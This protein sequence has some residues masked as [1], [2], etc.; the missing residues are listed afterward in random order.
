[1]P[2]KKYSRKRNNS[3]QMRR[4]SRNA[5]AYNHRSINMFGGALEGDYK[6]EAVNSGIIAQN[7]RNTA[8]LQA[9]IDLGLVESYGSGYRTLN[10]IEHFQ[11]TV[12]TIYDNFVEDSEGKYFI[13]LI[14]Y[15]NHNYIVKVK[16]NDDPTDPGGII[17]FTKIISKSK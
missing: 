14:P 4:K 12:K 5:S 13:T 3:R 15:K 9:L 6:V 10:F 8:G 11:S 7:S 17:K 1:M 2:S 16:N